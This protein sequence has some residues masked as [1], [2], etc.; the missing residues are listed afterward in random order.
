[1]HVNKLIDT[2]NHLINSDHPLPYF[3]YPGEKEPELVLQQKRVHKLM[4]LSDLTIKRIRL[5]P[6]L[7]F[8]TIIL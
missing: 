4:S 6:F 8:R 5:C 1:M 2:I 7:Y 3:F